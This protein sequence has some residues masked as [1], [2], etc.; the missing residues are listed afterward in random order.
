MLRGIAA[1]REPL[2][3][4]PLARSDY[5]DKPHLVM[6]CTCGNGMGL[7]LK[8]LAMPSRESHAGTLASLF[9]YFHRKHGTVSRGLYNPE[10]G[11]ITH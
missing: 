3:Q 10:N 6:S 11:E 8:R 9:E 2:S 5:G 1:P 7:E 4:T